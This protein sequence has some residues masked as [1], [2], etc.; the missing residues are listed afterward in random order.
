MPMRPP[1]HRPPGWKPHRPSEKR[2]DP[3]Y[4][5]DEHRAFRAAVLKRDR[6]RCTDPN[7]PTGIVKLLYQPA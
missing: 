3:Y 7:C 1:T 4:L 5:S 2:V 6:Y